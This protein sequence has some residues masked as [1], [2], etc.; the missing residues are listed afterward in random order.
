MK[1]KGR[2][3]TVAERETRIR[4]WHHRHWIEEEKLLP[5]T[6]PNQPLPGQTKRPARPS[7]VGLLLYMMTVCWGGKA[8]GKGDDH[9]IPLLPLPTTS[10]YAVVMQWQL[11]SPHS[12]THPVLFL[13]L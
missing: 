10:G 6:P 4:R 7:R 5:F 12:L 3:R 2:Q 1:T 13:P 9:L 8:E 11:P